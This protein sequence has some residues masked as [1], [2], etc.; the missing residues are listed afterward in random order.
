MRQY[1]E[2]G[3]LPEVVDGFRPVKRVQ[4][5]RRAGAEGERVYTFNYQQVLDGYSS[6]GTTEMAPGD[7]L[8]VPMRRLFE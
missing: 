4:L 6:I 3:I 5:R 2:F 1:Q 7:T 8:V